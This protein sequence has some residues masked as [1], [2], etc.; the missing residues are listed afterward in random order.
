MIFDTI[1]CN[2]EEILLRLAGSLGKIVYSLKRFD[3]YLKHKDKFIEFFLTTV[4]HKDTEMRKKA[5]F[6]LPCFNQL[7]KDHCEDVDFQELYYQFSKEP[8]EEIKRL[9]AVS[10]HEAFKTIWPE[11]DGMRLRETFK[12]LL[13]DSTKEIMICLN[14][15]MADSLNYYANHHAIKIFAN[16]QDQTPKSSSSHDNFSSEIKKSKLMIEEKKKGA[17][18]TTTEVDVANGD[19]ESF[20]SEVGLENL[21]SDLLHKLLIFD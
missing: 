8:D 9:I 2:V 14:H 16:P 17:Q 20:D 12:Y 10:I 21:F 11:E 19:N 1:D 4:R 5:A 18:K 15:G 3:L 6:N 7:Y 13:E